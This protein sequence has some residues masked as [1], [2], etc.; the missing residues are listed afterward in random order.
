MKYIRPFINHIFLITVSLTAITHSTWSFSTVFTGAE[1]VQFTFAWFAW[2]VPGF[3]MAF[4]IDM[5][6]LSMANRIRAGERHASILLAFIVLCLAMCYA[7]FWY[8]S[9]HMPLVPVS[10]GVRADWQSNV[11]LY[12]D[13]AVWVFP[14]L[15]P[16]ALMLYTFKD[17]RSETNEKAVILNDTPITGIPIPIEVERKPFLALF[18]RNHV[19][20]KEPVDTVDSSYQ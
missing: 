12:R 8:V 17:K 10:A 13:Q 20:P 14:S 3:L 6:L 16:I 11:Q 1:P 15:L 9:S 19:Q 2:F 7:Q 18:S 5:G 4:S